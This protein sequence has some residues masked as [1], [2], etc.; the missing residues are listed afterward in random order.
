MRNDI[1]QQVT[2]QIISLIESGQ[3]DTGWKAPWASVN[4]GM[5]SN[6]TT[7]RTYNGVNVLLLWGAQEQ[8]GYRSSQW[9]SFKQWQ[10]AGYR[11]QDAK[12][13][14][15]Q[16]V[17]WK[18]LER[19]DE[20]GNDKKIPLMRFSYVFNA[21]LAVHA[22]TGEPFVAAPVNHLDAIE[23]ADNVLFASGAMIHHQG[24]RAYYHRDQDAIYLPVKGDFHTASGY[25][26]TALHELTHWTGHESRLNRQFG[27][28]FGD[29]AYAAEE[30]VAELG[31]AFLCAQIG[32]ESETREDHA[33]YVRNWLKVL[34]D[35]KTAIITAASAASKAADFVLTADAQREAA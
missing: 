1:A 15:Q 23:S 25:Y 21:D 32:I 10:Q 33:K 20:D 7:G 24:S 29:E 2:D 3:A 4:F 12:G 14:G 11:L 22:E 35:D 13:K 30:L 9:A 26:S 6:A 5:P 17:F 28:R 34:R 19:K 27:K 16:I 8:H 31:A 18:I